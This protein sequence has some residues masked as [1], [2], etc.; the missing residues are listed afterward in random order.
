MTL[1]VDF[2]EILQLIPRIAFVSSKNAVD[3]EI[4]ILF[5]DHYFSVRSL[6]SSNYPSRGGGGGGTSL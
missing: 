5:T 2:S 4:H 3:L 6:R 1:I